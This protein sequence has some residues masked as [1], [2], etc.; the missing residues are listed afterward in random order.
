M[1]K[2]TLFITYDIATKSGQTG[3]GA[4]C[5][6]HY[7]NIKLNTYYINKFENIILEENDAKSVVITNFQCI[8]NKGR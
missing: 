8:C 6:T 1:R 4:R 2:Y 3:T 7:R 5:S